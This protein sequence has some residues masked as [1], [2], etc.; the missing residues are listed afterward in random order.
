[1]RGE[2]TIRWLV[3][4][5]RDKPGE[6]AKPKMWS[7]SSAQ[8]M[9]HWPLPKLPTDWLR[10]CCWE[11][12]EGRVAA[13]RRL[14]VWT[15][16]GD[17]RKATTKPLDATRSFECAFLSDIIQMWWYV[18][19]PVKVCLDC[20]A[21]VNAEPLLSFSVSLVRKGSFC[22]GSILNRSLLLINFRISFCHWRSAPFWG[23]LSVKRLLPA[24]WPCGIWR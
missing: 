20:V 6:E 22:G 9:P 23:D 10:P 5:W 18:G 15:G 1:M 12:W 14:P 21:R 2:V 24:H 7:T 13:W 3:R 19:V 11:H 8:V 16:S 17:V 4:W